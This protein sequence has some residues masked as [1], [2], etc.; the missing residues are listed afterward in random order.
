MDDLSKLPYRMF[1]NETLASI[2]AFNVMCA[3]LS[4]KYSNYGCGEPG[5]F[6]FTDFLIDYPPHLSFARSL[7]SFPSPFNR[8]TKASTPFHTLVR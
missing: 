7:S 3:H 4:T 8:G 6:D 5:H 2:R 1:S